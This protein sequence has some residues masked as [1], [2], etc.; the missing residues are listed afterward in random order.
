MIEGDATW[1]SRVAARARAWRNTTLS[2]L[3]HT[4]LLILW[5]VS[6]PIFISTLGAE[7]FGVWILL[8]AIVGLG[9]VFS[10]GF[11]EATIRFVAKYREREDTDT[12]RKIIETCLLLYMLLGLFFGVLVATLAEWIA[13]DGFDLAGEAA[14]DCII[15]LRLVGVALFIASFLKTFEA[16]INGYE[17]FD[18]SA[19]TGMITRSFIILSA[20][21]LALTGY[22]F[23]WMVAVTVLGLLGQMIAYRIIMSRKFIDRIRPLG[24]YHRDVIR[25]I[26]GFGTQS[27]LQ[28]TAGALGNIVDRFLVGIII[29]PAAAGIYSI[30]LQLAQQMHLLLVRG[31]AFLMPTAARAAASD[32]DTSILVGQY[33]SALFVT[34]LLL[35]TV[36]APLYILA[37]DILRFWVGQEYADAGEVVLRY[38]TLYFAALSGAVAS[39]YVVNGAGL[40]T[41][42]TVGNLL[43]GIFIAGGAALLLPVFD[44]NG[45]GIA[46]LLALPTMMIAIYALHRHVFQSSGAQDSLWF[47][48]LLTLQVSALIILTPILETYL[49]SDFLP[50]F[51]IGT[52]LIAVGVLTLAGPF[53]MRTRILQQ[54]GA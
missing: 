6:T 53:W 4:W 28:T 11:G 7:M 12:I 27:W 24:F 14:R 10:F 51:G 44:L 3:D 47:W 40:A 30:C 42:N 35:G 29:D 45:I 49:P 8:N 32:R 41:W 34:L 50:L 36:L 19:R 5:A 43:H 26:L 37:G 16:V 46:R 1:F 20:V 15:G 17:R 38:L 52:L 22:G 18:I 9:G 39:F 2:M 31:L 13:V 23:V 48:F 54:H 25:E 21:A 33:R